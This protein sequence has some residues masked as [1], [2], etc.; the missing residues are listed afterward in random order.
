M[1]RKVI[2]NNRKRPI[3]ARKPRTKTVSVAVKKYVKR[4]L[5][6][7]IENKCIQING[8]A[9]FGAYNATFPNSILNAYPMAPL[10]T[11]WSISQGVGQGNR[12]GN[13]I[14]TR[15]IYLNYVLNPRAYDATFNPTPTPMEIQ[16]FLG[17]VKNSPGFLP[18]SL[19]VARIFQ[20]GGSAASPAGTLRDL[21]TPVN[22]DYWV[23][24]K[25]WT[26]K[27]GFAEAQGQGNVGAS[28]YFT[29]NDFKLNQVRRLDITKYLPKIITFD[30]TSVS[31]TSKNLFFMYQAVGAL[32]T[33][34][35]SNALPTQ[36]DFWVDFHFEDA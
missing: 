34:L 16:L 10:N 36:M 20:N 4:T 23:I 25:R 13:K 35:A 18:A 11:Y 26:H 15:K 31:T 29:N 33:P 9:G 2:R 28:Q 17:Y 21:I 1:A 12:I 6:A 19:D 14:T 27:V 22:S 24:K 3:R 32:G 7:N 8:G 30:D 5:N